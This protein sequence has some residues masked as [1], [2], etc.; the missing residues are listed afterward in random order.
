MLKTIKKTD[1]FFLYA[2][3]SKSGLQL[4]R[5]DTTSGC[6]RSVVCPPENESGVL[7]VVLDVREPIVPYENTLVTLC[8]RFSWFLF[9]FCSLALLYFLNGKRVVNI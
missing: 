8:E 5:L 3:Y 7:G 4:W 2:A 9:C 1:F 6:N